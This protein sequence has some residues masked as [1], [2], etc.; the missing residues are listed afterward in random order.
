MM[1]T[2]AMNRFR[3]AEVPEPATYRSSNCYDSLL[4]I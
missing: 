4:S 3:I 1:T 2:M